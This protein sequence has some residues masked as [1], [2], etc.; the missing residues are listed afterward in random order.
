MRLEAAARHVWAVEQ[1]GV[2][3]G[4]RLLEVGCGHGVAISLVC[5][6]LAAGHVIGL[7]RS[8]KMINAAS[9]RNA[10]SIEAGLASLIAERFEEVDL[11]QDA[12][13]KIFA[14]HVT[15][16]WRQPETLLPLTAR[17]LKPGGRLYLFNQ[18]PGWREAGDV[19][20]FIR[21]LTVI[22]D[23]HG[24]RPDESAVENLEPA[25]VVCVRAT[26]SA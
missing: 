21:K 12:F 3:P 17:L 18:S 26:P 20:G 22:L 2:E 25:P 4:E 8:Q 5:K 6:R 23:G 10:G 11:A 14:T 16:F 7:D 24:F 19:R 13:D 15:A 1:L 9:K